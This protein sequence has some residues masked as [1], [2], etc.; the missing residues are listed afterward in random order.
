MI[1]T[2]KISTNFWVATCD[3]KT[4]DYGAGTTEAEARAGLLATLPQ[5]AVCELGT[6]EEIAELFWYG[7]LRENDEF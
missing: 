2:T 6:I 5:E 4:D 3:E 1:Q 7:P